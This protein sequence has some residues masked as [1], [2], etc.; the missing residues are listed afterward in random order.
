MGFVEAD[1]E[2][3]GW[4]LPRPAVDCGLEDVAAAPSGQRDKIGAASH[5]P[6]RSTASGTSSSYEMVGGPPSPAAPSPLELERC[7]DVSL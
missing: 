4:Q 3:S 1:L 2:E 6:G 5:G 7:R